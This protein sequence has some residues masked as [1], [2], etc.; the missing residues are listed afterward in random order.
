MRER[1]IPILFVILFLSYAGIFLVELHYIPL[2]V[3]AILDIAQ[4]LLTVQAIFL[5]L[6]PLIGKPRHR[7]LPFTVGIV[8]LF[9]SLIT[10]VAVASAKETGIGSIGLW[11]LLFIDGE[12]FV[13]MM[14]VYYASVLGR[15]FRWRF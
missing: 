6:T 15:P 13:L 2:N 4:A 11:V 8:S 9:V 3:S 14:A 1:R 7:L 5:G 12:V 10:L